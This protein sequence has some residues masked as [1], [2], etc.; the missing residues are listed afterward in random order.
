MGVISVT[1]AFHMCRARTLG[2][3]G[4]SGST[5]SSFFKLKVTRGWEK[6]WPHVTSSVFPNISCCFLHVVISRPLYSD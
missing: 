6:E 1:A 4:R 5:T 3:S 2:Y